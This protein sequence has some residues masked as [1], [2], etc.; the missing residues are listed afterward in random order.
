MKEIVLK[1]IIPII[2]PALILSCSEDDIDVVS[3][4]SCE[5]GVQNGD[6][7]SIDCGG[8]CGNTCLPENALEGEIVSV[9]E[10]MSENEYIL[11]GSLLIRDGA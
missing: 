10:L 7:T 6:E 1:I 5:D 11:T 3:V 2:I 8:T 4:I 9:L